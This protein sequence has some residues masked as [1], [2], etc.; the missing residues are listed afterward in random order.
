MLQIYV[1]ANN[2]VGK[3]VE[4]NIEFE[5]NYKELINYLIKKDEVWIPF[6]SFDMFEYHLLDKDKVHLNFNIKNIYFIWY[7]IKNNIDLLES[8]YNTILDKDSK[9]INTLSIKSE[10]P[11]VRAST[12]LATMS[13]RITKEDFKL[14]SSYDY[15]KIEL[16]YNETPNT[17]AV[18][19]QDLQHLNISEIVDISRLKNKKI[20]TTTDDK[21]LLHFDGYSAVKIKNNY[22]LWN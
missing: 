1:R 19:F 6:S 22:I 7:Y 3:I 4:L 20:I 9:T 14:L 15:S 8:S 18:I 10:K 11:V 16:H 12:T 17:E 5:E 21:N 13:K 2:K